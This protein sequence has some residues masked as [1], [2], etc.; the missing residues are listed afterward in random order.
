MRYKRLSPD[1]EEKITEKF[2]RETGD[3]PFCGARTS[4]IE[5]LYRWAKYNTDVKIEEENK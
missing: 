5:K 3:F 4:D 2:L 1:V